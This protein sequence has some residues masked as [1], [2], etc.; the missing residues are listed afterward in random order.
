MGSDGL[1]MTA[2][3]FA[4]GLTGLCCLL[5][6]AR[7]AWRAVLR[8]IS[9]PPSRHLAPAA[10]LGF[11]AG[12]TLAVGFA[13]IQAGGVTA[14]ILSAGVIL[15]YLAV[16][17]LA[18]RWLPMGWTGA[19]LALG[20]VSATLDGRIPDAF[21]GALLGGL[22]LFLL[23]VW[24]LHRYGIEALG[25]GDIHLILGLGAFA[26]VATISWILLGAAVTGIAADGLQRL[27]PNREQTVSPTIAFGAHLSV[28]SML[29]AFTALSA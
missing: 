11:A 1:D 19:L 9:G 8:R 16:M 26:G 10:Q 12:A 22:V 4:M 6:T 17:D 25:Q 23:R 28:V 7:L 2:T 24:W 13:G 14:L 29:F 21:A 5:P 20:L 15:T 3:V 27:R 18:W